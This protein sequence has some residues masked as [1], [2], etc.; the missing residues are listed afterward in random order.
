MY[1]DSKL[2]F[3][4]TPEINGERV[5]SPSVLKLSM[6]GVDETFACESIFGKASPDLKLQSW[7]ADVLILAAD[8]NF[9]AAW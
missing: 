6:L 1:C 3:H 5:V 9:A 7:S 4:V 8:V 2:S